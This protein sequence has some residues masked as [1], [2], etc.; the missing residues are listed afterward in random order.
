MDLELFE[1]KTQPQENYPEPGKQLPAILA[2]L[3]FH[4]ILAFI[5]LRGQL[6]GQT[7][8]GTARNCL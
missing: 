3:L 8:R 1:L 4:G 5:F 6:G 7:G 2:S